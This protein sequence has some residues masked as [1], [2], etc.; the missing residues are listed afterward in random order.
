VKVIISKV[1]YFMENRKLST[2]LM[3]G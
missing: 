2:G 1:I 3:I